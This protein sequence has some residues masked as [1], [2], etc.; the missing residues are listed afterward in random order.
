MLK[1]QNFLVT[2]LLVYIL[3]IIFK[4][5]DVDKGDIS[6]SVRKPQL[7]PAETWAQVFCPKKQQFLT[8]L[9]PFQSR[10]KEGENL[11][12]KMCVTSQVQTSPPRLSPSTVLPSYPFTTFFIVGFRRQGHPVG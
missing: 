5:S 1:I 3:Y 9:N 8:F 2:G 6:V 11:L 4:R 12:Y 7:N 10:S